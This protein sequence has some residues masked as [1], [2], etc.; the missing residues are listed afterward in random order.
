[1]ERIRRLRSLAERAAI[2]RDDELARDYVRLARRI[3]ERHRLEL[4]VAFRR[5]TCDGCDRYLRPGV[6]VRVRLQAGHVVMTCECGRQQ[7]YPYD[8]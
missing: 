3:A 2:D 6:N 8:S 1:M 4:P 5:Y 7:R